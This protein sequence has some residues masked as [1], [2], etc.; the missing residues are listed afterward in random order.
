MMTVTFLLLMAQLLLA[1]APCAAASRVLW[2]YTTVWNGGGGVRASPAVAPDGSICTGADDGH[3]YYFYPNGTLKWAFETGDGTTNDEIY[4]MPAFT[5]DGKVVISSLYK[6]AG[7]WAIHAA[8]GSLAWKAP[9]WSFGSAKVDP[10]DGT[11]LYF[12]TTSGPFYALDGV[13][14]SVKWKTDTPARWGTAQ[15]YEQMKG[16]AIADGTVYAGSQNGIVYAL[17]SANGHV[18]WNF[19]TGVFRKGISGSTPTLS[20]D[21]ETL[22]V[23][24]GD[25][26]LYALG[27]DL[28]LKWR[29]SVPCKSGTDV[30][31]IY[32]SPAVAADG[33]VY[34][35]A[36]YLPYFWALNPDGTLKWRYELQG[37]PNPSYV[38]SS[39]A[40]SNEGTVYFQTMPYQGT[41]PP[42]GNVYALDSNGTLRWRFY[43][44]LGGGGRNL[45]GGQSS[46]GLSADATV[47]YIGSTDHN[48]YALRAHE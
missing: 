11:T 14:G 45:G 24:S 8:N 33:T 32:T 41:T 16:A 1:L 6:Y 34:I 15:G 17:D 23:G 43:P 10:T 44:G 20:P 37:N 40:V 4:G 25:C 9:Y 36:D 13:D 5:Q 12:G 2:N 22:Y 28:V 47:L 35:G 19:T 26:N 46:P 31:N 48:L 7:L 18:R 27:L 21:G 3:V 29:F 38:V 42:E 39:P 30:G